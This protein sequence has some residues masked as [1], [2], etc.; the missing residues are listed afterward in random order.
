MVFDMSN[1]YFLW[2]SLTASTPFF[3]Q[4]DGGPKSTLEKKKI[5]ADV[6]FE[7]Q[8]KQLEEVQSQ[9]SGEMDGWWVGAM[10]IKDFLKDFLP[11]ANKPLPDI[12]GDPFSKVHSGAER[13]CYDPFVSAIYS[14]QCQHQITLVFRL[15]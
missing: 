5:D 3:P 1:A 12:W 2:C 13:D 6:P 15:I 9:L 11:P 8:A 4:P 10:P 14:C 7:S